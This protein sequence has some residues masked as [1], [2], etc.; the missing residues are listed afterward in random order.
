MRRKQFTLIELLVVIAIIAILAAM[1]LPALSRSRETSRRSVCMSNLHEISLG[2]FQYAGDNDGMLVSPG[3]GLRVYCIVWEQ[4]VALGDYGLPVHETADENSG[5]LYN[6]PSATKPPRGFRSWPTEDL[7][8]MDKYALFSYLETQPAAFNP[9]A[10]G[11]SPVRLSDGN[12]PLMA[13]NVMQWPVDGIYGSNH[14][15]AHTEFLPATS[16]T[17]LQPLPDGFNQLWTDG[18]V[19][20][21]GANDIPGPT[22]YVFRQISYKSWFIEQEE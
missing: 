1:L 15:H 2:L 10:I 8:L 6:C 9:S 12:L 4:A 3:D 11:K 22:D 7:F 18:H 13:D 17:R 5:T 19:A 20:W 16:Y 21:Y 14:T